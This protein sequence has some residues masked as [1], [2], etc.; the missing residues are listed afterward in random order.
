MLK[1]C[2]R[3]DERRPPDAAEG[4]AKYGFFV[5]FRLAARRYIDR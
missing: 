5:A 1:A 3:S 2:L 4:A